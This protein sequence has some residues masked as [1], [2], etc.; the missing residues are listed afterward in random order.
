MPFLLATLAAVCALQTPACPALSDMGCAVC[1]R[2]SDGRCP[3]R[4]CHQPCVS[5]SKPVAT[6]NFS[7]SKSNCMPAN[8]WEAVKPAGVTCVGNATGC[9][10]DCAPPGPAP[11]PPPPT[12]PTPPS[13]PPPPPPPPGPCGSDLDCSL[14]G[15]CTAGKCACDAPW[16]GTRCGVLEFAVASPAAGVS[17]ATSPFVEAPPVS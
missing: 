7:G 8:W 10:K 5:T 11:P 6:S 15:I 9:R 12:P 16:I 17:D 3:G 13:P 14:N 1:T 4:W 2:A